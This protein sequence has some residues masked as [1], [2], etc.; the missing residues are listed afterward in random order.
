MVSTS[1]RSLVGMAEYGIAKSLQDSKTEETPLQK[2]LDNEVGESG[3]TEEDVEKSFA[4]QVAE[5][6][7]KLL[8][9]K[10]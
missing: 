5:T 3:K 6:Q 1:P 10:V 9:V 2:A 4:E 7:N 8:G